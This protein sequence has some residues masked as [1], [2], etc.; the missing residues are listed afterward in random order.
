MPACKTIID[1]GQSFPMHAR[2]GE[3]SSIDAL[4]PRPN[5]PEG[6]RFNALALP[7]PRRD[8][9]SSAEEVQF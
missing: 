8:F 5:L 7:A 2:S 4:I 6:L 3:P 1:T 9:G